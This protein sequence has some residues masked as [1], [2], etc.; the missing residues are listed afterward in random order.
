M[1]CALRRKEKRLECQKTA[2]L[3]DVGYFALISVRE[4]SIKLWILITL[5]L[6]ISHVIR[7]FWQCFYK[8]KNFWLVLIEPQ[9]FL[10]LIYCCS[11]YERCGTVKQK[12]VEKK[13]LKAKERKAE[14]VGI[15]KYYKGFEE[16]ASLQA[17]C[18]N[19][20]KLQKRS[21]QA[22]LK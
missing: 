22:S 8:T 11:L 4:C 12:E 1:F 9:Q 10:T 19:S 3:R 7:R 5:D 6:L 13:K 15:F 16:R 17:D 21:V 2:R 20:V 14:F 18:K